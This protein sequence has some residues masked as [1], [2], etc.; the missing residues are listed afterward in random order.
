VLFFFASCICVKRKET[1]DT[2]KNKRT[3]QKRQ[4][5]CFQM[6]R[7][8]RNGNSLVFVC[9]ARESCGK[10]CSFSIEPRRMKSARGSHAN[11]VALSIKMKSLRHRINPTSFGW[12]TLRSLMGK[13]KKQIVP[14]SLSLT[15]LLGF[16]R[17]APVDNRSMLLTII[18]MMLALSRGDSPGLSLSPP[19]R[20]TPTN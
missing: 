15:R 9:F 6:N 20:S 16:I 5:N 4:P 1:Q 3:K 14:L 11:W 19:P 18:L 12:H 8:C 7:C 13:N 10:F 2:Q 17:L